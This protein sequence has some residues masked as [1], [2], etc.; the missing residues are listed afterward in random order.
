M[1]QVWTAKQQSWLLRFSNNV[2]GFMANN[3]AIALLMTEASNEGYLSGGAEA[4]TDTVVQ[5]VLPA[6]TAALVFS[7]AGSFANSSAIL[8]TVASNRQALEI[9][10]P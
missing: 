3:D 8:A 2:V 6:A 4:L 5:G 10:R 1:A 9:L 7:A